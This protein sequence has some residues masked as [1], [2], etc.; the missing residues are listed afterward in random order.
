ME[1]WVAQG[2]YHADD[3]VDVVEDDQNATFQLENG[4]QIYCGFF[5]TESLREDRNPALNITTLDGDLLDDDGPLPFDNNVENSFHV[6]TGTGTDFTAI[7]DGC[8]VRGGNATV[9]L[10]MSCG[11]S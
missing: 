5:G 6:V 9:C 1:V 3:G 7:L 11:S 4:I 10:D 8:T 2:T